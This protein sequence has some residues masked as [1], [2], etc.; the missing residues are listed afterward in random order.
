M[1][2]KG[3]GTAGQQSTGAQPQAGRVKEQDWLSATGGPGQL[4]PCM[5]Q[6]PMLGL[7][8]KGKM[9]S[10]QIWIEG[11]IHRGGLRCPLLGS[12]RQLWEHEQ[13]QSGG[14]RAHPGDVQDGER[15]E[16]RWRQRQALFP[17]HLLV[18]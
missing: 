17:V 13:G 7:L 6:W 8:Q 3:L 18:S 14:G 10:A 11:K 4:L 16:G 2:D 9:P 5:C 12:R 15:G 1:E